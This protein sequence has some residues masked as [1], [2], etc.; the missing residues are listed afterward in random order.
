MRRAECLR[1]DASSAALVVA[2]VANADGERADGLARLLGHQADDD[3]RVDPARQKRAERDVADE[4]ASYRARHGRPNELEPL[5][6]CELA[7]GGLELPEALRPDLAVLPDEDV[8]RGQPANSRNAGLDAW[9][10]LEREVRVERPR[11]QLAP[12]AGQQEQRLQL[13]CKCKRTVG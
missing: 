1:R 6:V 5:L 13:G 8:P 3:R 2:G 9:D 7:G 10:V 12:H 11:I 4:A